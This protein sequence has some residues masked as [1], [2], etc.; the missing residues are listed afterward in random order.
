VAKLDF[1]FQVEEALLVGLRQD[2]WRKL[3]ALVAGTL[4]EH[5]TSFAVRR[6]GGE[7]LCHRQA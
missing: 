4:A 7:T 2:Y 5:G 6:G 1:D 3:P